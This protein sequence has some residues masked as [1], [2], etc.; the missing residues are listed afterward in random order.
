M[1]FMNALTTL[2]TKTAQRRPAV[3]SISEKKTM[4]PAALV[5]KY[6]SQYATD[7]DAFTGMVGAHG[8]KSQA[9]YLDYL[10]DVAPKSKFGG[11][12]Q[13]GRRSRGQAQARTQIKS[14]EKSLGTNVMQALLAS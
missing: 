1:K 2:L 3:A 11:P 14:Q 6:P 5:A 7:S 10:K 8:A 4:T 12:D 13:G 9:A